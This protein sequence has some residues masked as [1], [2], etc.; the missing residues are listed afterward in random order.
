[1]CGLAPQNKVIKAIICNY[2]TLKCLK[3]TRPMLYVLLSCVLTLSQM[4]PTILK[5]R[6]I[7]HLIKVTGCFIW[8][9]VNGIIL[10]LPKSTHAQDMSALWLSITMVSTK[11]YSHTR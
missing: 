3:T 4:F 6:E 8:S 5:P 2:S 10:P 11:E 9:P 1:M 7:S